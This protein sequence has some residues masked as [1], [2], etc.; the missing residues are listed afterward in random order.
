[1]HVYDVFIDVTI[2]Y[3]VVMQQLL[4]IFLFGRQYRSSFVIERDSALI[5]SLFRFDR[6]L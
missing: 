4:F 3:I 2:K 5:E 6:R 1:M